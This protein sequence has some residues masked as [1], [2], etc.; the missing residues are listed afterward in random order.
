MKRAGFTMTE[1]LVVIAI[2]GTLGGIAYP[3]ATSMIGSAREAACL[4]NLRSIGIGLQAFLQDNSNRLPELAPGRNS[5]SQDIPVM[6]TVLLEHVGNEEAFHCPADTKQFQKTGSSY[7]WNSTQSGRHIS[8]LAFFG[9][10]GK[11]E[12]IPL[13]SD[14]EAWHPHGTNILYADSSSSNEL[15]FKTKD[16]D[17]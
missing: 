6:E 2:I 10:E 1:M 8:Q 12:L 3:I 13:V 5:K 17:R 4:Q 11:P 15:R 16:K 9:M 7:G 14:K